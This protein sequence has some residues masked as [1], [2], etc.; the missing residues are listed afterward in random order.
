MMQP[1]RPRGCRIGST[2]IPGHVREMRV[3]QPHGHVFRVR[4]GTLIAESVPGRLRYSGASLGYQLSS[5]IAGGPSPLIATWLLSTY[6][7]GMVIALFIAACGNVTL[8]ATAFL[9]DYTN[10]D[11]SLR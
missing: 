8:V 2:D 1:T 5:V 6:H 11:I 4:R 10:K 3:R 9:T 7:S